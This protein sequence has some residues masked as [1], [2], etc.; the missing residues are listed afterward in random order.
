M[1]QIKAQIKVYLRQLKDEYKKAAFKRKLLIILMVLLA[2]LTVYII[3]GCILSLIIWLASSPAMRERHSFFYFCFSNFIGKL[4]TGLYTFL[5]LYCIWKIGTPNDLRNEPLY[6]D[7]N[8]TTYMEKGVH[9]TARPMSE[10]E[11]EKEFE[12]GNFEDSYNVVLGSLDPDGKKVVKIRPSEYGEE[13]RNIMLCGPSG[14]MKSRCFVRNEIINSTLRGETCVI[15]D[16]S[17]ELYMECNVW[18]RKKAKVYCVN[19]KDNSYSDGWNCLKET[20]SEFTG[21]IDPGRLNTFADVFIR[22]CTEGKEDPFW[23]TQAVNYLKATI[24]YVAW[25]HE[26]YL[27]RNLKKLYLHVA[28]DLPDEEKKPIAS[29]FKELVSLVWCKKQIIT[30]GARF[31][32]DANTLEEAFQRIEDS[33]PKYNIQ[34]VT[35]ALQDFNNTVKQAYEKQTTDVDFIP[36]GQVGKL[37]YKSVTFEG[38]SENA[39]SSGIVTTL[40]KL[41]LFTDPMLTYNLSRDGVDLK[42]INNEQSIVFVGMP[43]GKTEIRPITSLFFTFLYM[44]RIDCYDEAKQRAHDY[45]IKNQ[46]VDMNII[47]DDFFSIGVIGGNP[48]QYASWMSTVRKR[49]L[50]TTMIIQN[51][52]ELTE[53]YGVN[54]S[55]TITT[56]CEYHLVFGAS[57]QETMNFYSELSG[58]AT[59]MKVTE[60][61]TDG[62]IPWQS[63]ELS[64][65]TGERNLYNA[66]EIWTL[67]K[68]QCFAIKA[69]KYPLPLYKLSYEH[70]PIYKRHEMDTIQSVYKTISSYDEKITNERIRKEHQDKTTVDDYIEAIKPGFTVDENGEVNNERYIEQVSGSALE[71]KMSNFSIVEETEKEEVTT[72]DLNGQ[73]IS[74]VLEEDDEEESEDVYVFIEASSQPKNKPMPNK[75]DPPRVSD[76]PTLKSESKAEN[77]IAKKSGLRRTQ[78]SVGIAT[79]PAI[80]QAGSRNQH[81]SAFDD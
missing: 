79:T 72:I 70:N 42:K 52:G 12:V 62:V 20:V 13:L 41:S 51:I 78:K 19:F 15:T 44:N 74:F 69:H 46:T 22:N 9:G 18:C 27:F 65:T 43:D 16:P 68:S 50:Y 35:T 36:D 64:V 30:T 25:K 17:M 81:K 5:F 49:N 26:S 6:Q 23:Y 77:E 3:I 37:A 59:V 32:Y 34:E 47:L 28:A 67:D 10:T 1:S 29:Q 73:K 80:H 60:R 40:G 45:G 11:A 24:G 66:D 76:K 31:G 7:E 14:S 55:K 75:E 2:I 61:R 48:K 58:L 4:I 38:L 39:K 54:N 33:A 63:K 8:G 56:N 53:N 71:Q 21:R 57:D